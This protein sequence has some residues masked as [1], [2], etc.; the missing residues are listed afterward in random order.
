MTKSKKIQSNLYIMVTLWKW[1]GD[2]YIKG[3]LYMQVSFK[4]FWN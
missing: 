3:D 1:P 4:L 2:R